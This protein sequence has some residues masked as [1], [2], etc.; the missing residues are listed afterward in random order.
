LYLYLTNHFTDTHLKKDTMEHSFFIKK[1]WLLFEAILS[2]A[3]G[4]LFWLYP[5]VFVEAAVMLI[6]ISAVIYALIAFITILKHQYAAGAKQAVIVSATIAFLVGIILLVAPALFV[7]FLIIFLGLI[8]IAFGVI[9][10]A[11]IQFIRKQR[12]HFSALHFLSPVVILIAGIIILLKPA[13]VADIIEKICAIGMIYAG[14]SGI[15]YT[16]HIKKDSIEVINP[17][18]NNTNQHD[19]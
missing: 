11:E 19:E 15:I 1:E 13:Q 3:I 4:I 14:L 2:L 16:L 17:L 6:G 18:N 5:S 8:V 7:N 9:Q 12:K 10:T